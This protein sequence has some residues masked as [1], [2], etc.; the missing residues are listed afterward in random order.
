MAKAGAYARRRFRGRRWPAPASSSAITTAPAPNNNSRPLL[1]AAPDEPQALLMLGSALALQQR[2]DDALAAYEHAAV[3][4][5][6]QRH[7]ALSD[8]ADP[9]QPRPQSGSADAMPTGVAAAPSN[10]NAIALLATDRARSARAADPNP[11][12][13]TEHTGR[14]EAAAAGHDRSGDGTFL[15]KPRYFKDSRRCASGQG[16]VPARESGRGAPAQMSSR[17]KRPRFPVVQ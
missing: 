13:P 12:P 8:R 9:A 4:G 14:S 3:G 5:S 17:V 11:A 1:A 2:Y 15:L 6:R 16:D 7:G 10:P